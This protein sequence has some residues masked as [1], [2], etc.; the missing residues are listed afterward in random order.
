MPNVLRLDV[1]VE[2]IRGEFEIWTSRPVV[3]M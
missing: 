2:V 1:L 3:L